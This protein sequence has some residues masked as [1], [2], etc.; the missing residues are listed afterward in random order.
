MSMSKVDGE[1]LAEM[2]VPNLLDDL[3]RSHSWLDECGLV[4]R[5]HQ[6]GSL[7][8]PTLT[9]DGRA[10]ISFCT[11][12]YLGLS[13]HKDVLDAAGNALAVHGYSASESRR[14]GGNLTI[15]EEL[16]KALAA[17]KEVPA[18]MLTATGL[19]ANIAAVHG[20]IDAVQLAHRWYGAP[21]NRADAVILYDEYIHRSVRMGARIAYARHA[22][23][24]HN[25]VGHV[26]ELLRAHADKAALV[27]TEGVFSMD[28][29]L[30]NLPEL[31]E[32][33]EESGALLLVD[34]AHGTGIYGAT[35]TGTVEHFH[36][37][38]RV[39]L[40]VVT[41]SK[42]LGGLGGAVLADEQTIAM[43]RTF[44]SGYRFTSSLP[45]ELA[46]G[47]L[48]SV[49]ILRRDSS[50]R[51]K[52]WDNTR[53]LRAGLASLGLSTPG[54]GPIIPLLLESPEVATRLEIELLARGYWCAAVMPPLVKPDGCRLRLTVSAMHSP[55]HIDGLL[56]ALADLVVAGSGE[57][58]ARAVLQGGA[59]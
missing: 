20:V 46:A 13:Y 29:D 16:E 9:I 6:V 18:A 42:A 56:N 39:P 14:L 24:R 12:N 2:I 32:V 3:H 10:V 8:T 34:D 22:S 49:N 50:F 59:L 19:L 40:Q 45:A 5:E 57:D 47:L 23:F 17:Y 41:L 27:V 30:A 58:M 36:L 26:A 4:P 25:D 35:G 54:D 7:P 38:G 44:A 48:V 37:T 21:V 15:H 51:E 33:C 53:R 11:N 28:G 55:A 31:L 43:L 52:L 1:H